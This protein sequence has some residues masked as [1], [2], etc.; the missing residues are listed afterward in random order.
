[1]QVQVQVTVTGGQSL[2]A[3]PVQALS[4]PG[5]GA[6]TAMPAVA[7]VAT[8]RAVRVPAAMTGADGARWRPV[9]RDLWCFIVWN[10]PIGL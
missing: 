1:M 6:A 10:L 5:C 7:K 3:A 8:T 2:R 9:G 4:P